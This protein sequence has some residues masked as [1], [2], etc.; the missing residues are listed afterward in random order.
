MDEEAL[1]RPPQQAGNR[2]RSA[3]LAG[4]LHTSKTRKRCAF[5]GLRGRPDPEVLSPILCGKVKWS[6]HTSP[7]SAAPRSEPFGFAQEC[8]AAVQ[9]SCTKCASHLQALCRLSGL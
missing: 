6:R 4:K 5:D 7:S 9:G 1:R 3:A 8:C 2:S